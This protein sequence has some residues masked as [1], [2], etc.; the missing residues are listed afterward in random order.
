MYSVDEQMHEWRRCF[1]IKT[2]TCN[3]GEYKNMTQKSIN[4]SLGCVHIMIILF[5]FWGQ[6]SNF[7]N[8]N[9]PQGNKIF[10]Y[11]I[12]MHAVMCGL[13]MFCLQMLFP[14]NKKAFF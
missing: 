7:I 12:K 6:S 1:V 8:V 5:V 3:L 9:D 11:F 2:H 14:G 13:C 4:F 10:F